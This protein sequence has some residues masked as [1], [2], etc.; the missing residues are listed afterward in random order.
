MRR[1]ARLL[2]P[3][4]I[5]VIVAMVGQYHDDTRG[6]YEPSW[7]TLGYTALLMVG[8]YAAGLPDL[9]RSPRSAV[10]ACVGA[11]ATGAVGI[12]AAQLVTGSQLLPRFVVLASAVL[13]VPWLLACSVVAN[14]GRKQDRYHDRVLVVAGEEEVA[15]LRHDLARTPEHDAHLSAVL[16]HAEARPAALWDEPLVDQAITSGAT[17]LV[18]DRMAS[19]DQSIVAQAA[20]LH[21]S[22]VRIR[23]LALFY[24]QWLGK[25]PVSELE[26]VS[27]MFDIGELHRAR[28]GRA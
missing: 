14:G 4:G 10:T 8:A 26:R 25:L 28:Y 3:A 16:T 9:T 12:S 15:A 6:R 24:E 19:N 20:T 11:T 1:A 23:T 27:L 7:W 17:V 18:L 22:G 5:V 13:L 21:E 2:V